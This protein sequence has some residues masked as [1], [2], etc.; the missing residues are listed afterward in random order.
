MNKIL[1]I[2]ACVTALSLVCTG[3]ITGH[4][5]EREIEYYQKGAYKNPMEMPEFRR[6]AE[7]SD[8]FITI[9]YKHYD[10][11]AYE[12]TARW[13]NKSAVQDNAY[14]E[15]LLGFMYTRGQGVSKSASQAIKFYTRA[16]NRGNVI[17]QYNLAYLYSEGDKIF[18]KDQMAGFTDFIS[19]GERKFKKDQNL[20]MEWYKKA[21]DN[22][23]VPAQNKLA[24]LSAQSD[25]NLDQAER[26]A[27]VAVAKNP[28]SGEYADTY[29]WVLYKL[30]KYPEA[31]K[32]LER[33]LTL[34]PGEPIIFDHLGDTYAKMGDNTK[35]YDCW[36]KALRTVDKELQKKVNE[37]IL[38]VDKERA[39]KAQ[40]VKG[41][42]ASQNPENK[43]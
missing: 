20:A 39:L 43:E 42:D 35:A 15:C 38:A 4:D 23:F 6:D 24:Y 32:E 27:R 11:K 2:C 19:G 36:K 31:A 10:E 30:G 22:G 37:K 25:K 29:G 41:A 7:N 16:A 21:A 5:G 9:A 26:L 17:A 34:M 1:K 18:P 8:P 28:N 12:E 33:A 13:L 3:C 40:P 14:S